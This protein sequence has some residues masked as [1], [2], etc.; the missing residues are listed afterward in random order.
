MPTGIGVYGRIESRKEVMMTDQLDQTGQGDPLRLLSKRE[1]LAR[2]GVTYATVWAWMIRG[3]F[4]R[5]VKL[6]NTKSSR[7][8]W[9]AH[10]IDQWL[11]SRPQQRLK[12]DPLPQER[13]KAKIERH[14]LKEGK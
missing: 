1:V 14:I 6:V 12:G 8:G 4:P 9:Y 11:A 2:V 10:E 13:G 7:V 3:D 5:S